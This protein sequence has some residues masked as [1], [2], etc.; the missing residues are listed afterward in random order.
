M[1]QTVQE[2]KRENE[3]APL[4]G[5]TIIWRLSLL[6]RATL[7]LRQPTRT[8]LVLRQAIHARLN[9]R[10]QPREIS[11]LLLTIRRRLPLRLRAFDRGGAGGRAGLVDERDGG[12]EGREEREVVLR[13]ETESGKRQRLANTANAREGLNEIAT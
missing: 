4:R 10:L 1:R 13:D 12:V 3:I 11:R 5:V 9:C 8:E 2:E 7:S 6:I